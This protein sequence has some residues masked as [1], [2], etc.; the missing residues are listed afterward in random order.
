MMSVIQK[1]LQSP[2]SYAPLILRVP[3]GITLMAH[4]SQKLFGWFGGG[5][6]EGT[7]QFMSS[8]GLEPGVLMA[9]LAGSG[10]FFGGL[11]LLIGLLTRPSAFVV[12]FTMLV[13]ILSVHISNGLFLAN[14]GYEFGL[15]L[16][17]I[18]V[19]LLVSGS[20]RIGLDNLLAEKFKR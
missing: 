19:S 9:F 7:G 14:G 1:V 2:A 10:E 3:T 20:G 13:A 16:L 18:A 4:G 8:L 5:G 12:A 6:L 15:A 11:F 17:A